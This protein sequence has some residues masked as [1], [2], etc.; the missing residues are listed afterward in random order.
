MEF[1]EVDYPPLGLE[2]GWPMLSPAGDP[3]CWRAVRAMW[4]GGEAA[5]FVGLGETLLEVADSAS[6]LYVAGGYAYRLL[7]G[8]EVQIAPSRYLGFTGHASLGTVA[9]LWN[10]GELLVLSGTQ[11]ARYTDSMF[12]EDLNVREGSSV[13]LL[14]EG[15]STWHDDATTKFLAFEDMPTL[16]LPKVRLLAR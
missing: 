10:Y 5:C 12:Q 15:R 1:V 7:P 14:L 9:V 16:D 11:A 2:Q 3:R 4:T 6:G 8:G 13:G